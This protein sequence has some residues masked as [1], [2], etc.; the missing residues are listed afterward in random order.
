MK[1]YI[2]L[3]LL[4]LI[5]FA[6]TAQILL[7]GPQKIVIDVPR[8]RLLVSNF[9][10]GNLVV[11][12]SAG[13]QSLFVPNADFI[14]G[15]EIVGDTI[16]GVGSNRFIHAYNLETRKLVW[17]IKIPGTSYLSSITSDSAGC[18]FISCPK[19][20][21]IYKLRISDQS[22][23]EFAS[24]NGLKNPNGILLEK[25]KNRIVTIGDSPSPSLI[26]TI[27]LSDSSVSTLATTKFS[28]TDGI[29]R[30]K[31]GYHYL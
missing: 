13:N 27:S 8:N 9:N 6:S 29:T 30:D 16:F 5:A 23:W 17:N 31:F 18:L 3:S 15:L 12:D 1:K 4:M 10:D 19:L 22:Y 7:N 25:E 24:N 11:I 14:D 20:N 2:T 28:S 26:Q 21:K